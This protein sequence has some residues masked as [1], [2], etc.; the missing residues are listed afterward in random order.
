MSDLLTGHG[1]TGH[2]PDLDQELPE[3]RERKLRRS[4]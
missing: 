4:G 2:C 3:P 1:K